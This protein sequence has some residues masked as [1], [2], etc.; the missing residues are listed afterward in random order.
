MYY[1]TYILENYALFRADLS[2][3]G[4]DAEK[5]S[6]DRCVSL[7]FSGEYIYYINNGLVTNK[8]YRMDKNGGNNTVLYDD[9][10]VTHESFAVVGNTIFFISRGS[11]YSYLSMI[12]TTPAST[13]P[14]D[15]TIQIKRASSFVV[16][17]NELYF[18][19]SGGVLLAAEHL[20]YK[21]NAVAAD[22]T[23][24]KASV[25]QIGDKVDVIAL[26]AVGDRIYYSTSAQG[27]TTAGTYYIT[28]ASAT[29]VKINSVAAIDFA[30]YGSKVYYHKATSTAGVLSGDANFYSNNLSGTAE[31]KIA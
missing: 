25:Q 12:S 19:S 10:S 9:S 4:S 7:V 8:I 27:T 28:T 11:V 17:G 26:F 6:S 13:N 20:L 14:S 29:P 15:S 21:M 3:P 24:A 1:S 16:V 18:A 2:N 30:V 31:T 22:L 23:A 5:I